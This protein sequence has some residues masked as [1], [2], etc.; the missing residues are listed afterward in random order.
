VE[1]NKD[2]ST[3]IGIYNIRGQKV[4]ELPVQLTKGSET[5]KWDG[6]DGA[7]KPVAQGVYFIKVKALPDTKTQRILK[8]N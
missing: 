7:G 2:I 6:K 8:I 4:R 5:Y 1:S 3:R